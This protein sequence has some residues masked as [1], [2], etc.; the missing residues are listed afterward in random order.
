VTNMPIADL[1]APDEL[2]AH[3]IA[4]QGAN[5]ETLHR[6]AILESLAALE[7]LVHNVVFKSLE[8]KF[9]SGFAKWLEDKTKTDFDSRLS[10][11]VPLAADLAVDTSADLWRRYKTAKEI[12]NKVAHRGKRASR[13]NVDEVIQ[14]VREWISYLGSTIELDTALLKLKHWVESGNALRISSEADA[15]RVV[16][17]FFKSHSAAELDYQVAAHKGRSK[18]KADLI[19]DFGPTKVIVE[20]AFVKHR[21]HRASILDST[22]QHANRLRKATGIRRACVI[23]FEVNPM[24]QLPELVERTHDGQIYTVVINAKP[25]LSEFAD[26][27]Q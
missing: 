3:A 20:T 17:D 10:V 27:L 22:Q 13:Q 12:R 26:L 19:L 9:G 23:V 1:H 14:T 5:D 25:P 24:F 21:R 7:T 11:L 16:S 4:M 2:L 6:A 15:N 8:A 18:L